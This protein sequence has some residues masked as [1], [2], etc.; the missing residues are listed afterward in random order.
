[1]PSACHN[2]GET[3]DSGTPM[4]TGSRGQRYSPTNAAGFPSS[5]VPQDRPARSAPGWLWTE[6]ESGG[7]IP[8]LVFISWG[9]RISFA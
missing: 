2:E 5:G 1:M 6:S 9:Q 7:A 4:T 8:A 3:N